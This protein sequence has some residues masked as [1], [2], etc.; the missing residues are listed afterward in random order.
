MIFS[1]VLE[2]VFISYKFNGFFIT[3]FVKQ[4]KQQL[5]RTDAIPVPVP[6][7]PEPAQHV[8][9]N[10][11]RRGNNCLYNFRAPSRFGKGS[12]FL[13]LRLNRAYSPLPEQAHSPGPEG[14]K[15]KGSNL[16]PSGDANDEHRNQVRL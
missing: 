6:A 13:R 1:R 4:L 14:P 11:G 8:G 7:R 16:V 12:S 2:L 15:N 9:E 10:V 3:E 5:K